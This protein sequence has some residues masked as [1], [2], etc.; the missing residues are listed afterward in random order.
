[1]FDKRAF[2]DRDES[3][4]LSGSPAV[5]HWTGAQPRAGRHARERDSGDLDKAPI[6][7]ARPVIPDENAD[8]DALH[9]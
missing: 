3:Y 4:W 8:P 9:V 6:G 1:M 7:A 2:D 5:A